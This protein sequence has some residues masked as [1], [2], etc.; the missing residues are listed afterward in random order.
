MLHAGGTATGTATAGTTATGT[1]RVRALNVL[2]AGAGASSRE[3]R[4][5]AGRMKAA[6][7]LARRQRCRALGAD[8]LVRRTATATS[9]TSM[10]REGRGGGGGGECGSRR[11]IVRRARRL[12]TL[13]ASTTTGTDSGGGDASGGRAAATELRERGF[14]VLDGVYGAAQLDAFALEH[15]RLFSLVRSQIE[16]PPTTHNYARACSSS[17][18]AGCPGC[19]VCSGPAVRSALG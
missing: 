3:E 1:R 8:T 11:K 18:S 17:R 6:R 4:L 9:S 19:D 16:V 13:T 15:R 10:L 5:P 2:P 7:T 12:A 14:T